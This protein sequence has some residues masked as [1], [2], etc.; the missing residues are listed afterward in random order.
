MT[1]GYIVWRVWRTDWMVDGRTNKGQR[2]LIRGNYLLIC[3][4]SSDLWLFRHDYVEYVSNRNL[5][6]ST[7]LMTLCQVWPYTK[8]SRI[9]IAQV[10]YSKRVFKRYYSQIEGVTYIYVYIYVYYNRSG[11]WYVFSS[12]LPIQTSSR[13]SPTIYRYISMCIGRWFLITWHTIIHYHFL[14]F[15]YPISFLKWYTASGPSY[16]YYAL[17]TL[18]DKKSHSATILSRF[19]SYP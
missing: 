16:W 14:T 5:P 18:W 2:S 9:K 13:S 19:P 8:V 12:F 10:F 17:W 3:R 7:K 11:L 1:T 4:F 6:I 15:A